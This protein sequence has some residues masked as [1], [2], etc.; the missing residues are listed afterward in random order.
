MDITTK[1]FPILDLSGWMVTKYSDFLITDNSSTLL[2]NM[3]TK[4][5]KL[6]IISG[7]VEFFDVWWNIQWGGFDG[8][9]MSVI[10][11]NNIHIIDM[12]TMAETVIENAVWIWVDGFT[13]SKKENYN[14]VIYKDYTII[15]NSL[16]DK[17]TPL[18]SQGEV[19]RVFRKDGTQVEVKWFEGLT[20]APTVALVHNGTLYI[21]WWP[22]NQNYKNVIYNSRKEW[23]SDY[24]TEDTEKIFDFSEVTITQWYIV[25]DGTEITSLFTNLDSIFVGKRNGIYKMIYNVAQSWV[26][27][28]NIQAQRQSASGVLSQSSVKNVNGVVYFYDWVSARR[29][30]QETWL[31]IQDR[32]ISMNIQNDFECLQRDQ[33]FSCISFE[34]PYMKLHL[35]SMGK[36]NDTNFVLNVETNGWSIQ[37]WLNTKFCWSGYSTK[38]ARMESYFAGEDGKVYLDNVWTSYNWEEISFHW[39]SKGY[40]GGDYFMNKEF[41]NIMVY[42]E[43]NGW[44]DVETR[45]VSE[46]FDL[47]DVSTYATE[48]RSQTI[49]VSKEKVTGNSP[50]WRSTVA[51]FSPSTCWQYKKFVIYPC[52]EVVTWNKNYIEMKWS[53]FGEMYIEQIRYSSSARS[54]NIKMN[55]KT[56]TSKSFNSLK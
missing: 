37:K 19:M 48:W 39:I 55:Q 44:I 3:V 22:E 45:I 43:A 28:Y 54:A 25:G 12:D 26:L 50:V 18:F 24:S 49:G 41:S 34:Y 20:Y 33:N 30:D 40:A 11:D 21:G 31:S 27:F 52:R 1:N 17:W 51:N 16:K 42:W 8:S 2:E 38:N 29:L 13:K 14:I 7:Y 6:T 53:T 32:S 36:V 10:S 4:D 35:S 56:F 5:N 46:V 23:A 15:T 9:T 47:E